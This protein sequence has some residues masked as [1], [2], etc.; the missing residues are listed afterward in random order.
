MQSLATELVLELRLY[1]CYYLYVW[2]I[3][4]YNHISTPKSAKFVPYQCGNH[5]RYFE[6]GY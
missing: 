3:L 5:L 2:H 6:Y 4:I 1:Q